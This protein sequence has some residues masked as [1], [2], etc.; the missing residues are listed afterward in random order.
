MKDNFFLIKKKIM[1]TYV[2]YQK[3][4]QGSTDRACDSSIN[5]TVQFG[6]CRLQLPEKLISYIS[7]TLTNLNI[8]EN[9]QQKQEVT[10]CSS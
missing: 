3:L 10:Q 6:Y 8:Q 5:C 7:K 2:H 9:H 1:Y 4:N